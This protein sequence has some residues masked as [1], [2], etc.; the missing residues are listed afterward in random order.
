[1]NLQ[2][3]FLL[4]IWG[5]FMRRP[6]QYGGDMGTPG[7]ERHSGKNKCRAY[8]SEMHYVEHVNETGELVKRVRIE[9]SFMTIGGKSIAVVFR[10]QSRRGAKGGRNTWIFVELLFPRASRESWKVERYKIH[11]DACTRRR[12]Y[13]H[14]DFIPAEWNPYLPCGVSSSSSSVLCKEGKFCCDQSLINFS[15][16]LTRMLSSSVLILSSIYTIQIFHC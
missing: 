8:A 14:R 6:F 2:E 9:T 13:F 7:H 11:S 5:W 12:S 10:L 1:M 3:D 4:K 16:D 15:G